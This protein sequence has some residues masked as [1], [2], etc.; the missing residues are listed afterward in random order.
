[1]RFKINKKIIIMT[2]TIIIIIVLIDQLLKTTISKRIYN[3][4]INMVNGVLNLT[5]VKNTGG[6][7]GVGNNNVLFFII[8]NIIIISFLIKY[9]LSRKEEI[10]VINTISVSLIIAGGIANLTDRVF[11]GFVIDYI[12]ITPL[13]NYPVFNFADICVVV[14][15]I[16]IIIN[17]VINRKNVIKENSN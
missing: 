13:I 6:A 17:L 12:D 4:S 7:F 14:G 10:N 8:I 5:Y 3:S 16:L 15:F 11:R 9:M 1:M 2:I